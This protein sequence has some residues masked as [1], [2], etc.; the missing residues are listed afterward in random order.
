MNSHK[1]LLCALA[2]VFVLL[3]ATLARADEYSDYDQPSGETMGEDLVI[4]RPLSL[5]ATVLGTATWI[6]ALPFTI[7]SGSVGASAKA[8]IVE[9]AQYTFGRPLGQSES[10]PVPYVQR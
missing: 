6:I 8:L 3:T 5:V 4:V 2:S 7:P 1:S 10:K 9:P